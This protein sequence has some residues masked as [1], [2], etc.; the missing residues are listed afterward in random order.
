MIRTTAMI[1]IIGFGLSA[2]VN[3]QTETPFSPFAGHWTGTGSVDLTNGA[4]EPIKCRAAYDVLEHLH[5]LQLNIRCASA[6]YNFDLRGSATDNAGKVS[7]SWSE[8]TRNAAGT[9]TGSVKANQFEVVAKGPSFTA[10]LTVVTRGDQQTVSIKTQG[11]DPSQQAGPA[12][13]SIK[14]KRS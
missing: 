2:N 14:L 5:N 6:S 3:A 13:A 1:L 11:S 7:G 4:Q 10:I 12:G 8:A 9:L